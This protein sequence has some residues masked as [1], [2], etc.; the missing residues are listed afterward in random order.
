MV[1]CFLKKEKEE[2]GPLKNT[3]A[4]MIGFELNI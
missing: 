1:H 4:Y 3:H 2:N